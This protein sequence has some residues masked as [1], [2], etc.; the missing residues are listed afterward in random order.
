[1]GGTVPLAPPPVCA[2]F[3][4]ATE[5]KLAPIDFCMPQAS[6]CD[7]RAADRRVCPPQTFAGES[8]GGRRPVGGLAPI[9]TSLETRAGQALI[10]A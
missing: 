4:T 6:L 8:W 2:S 3:L 7:Q 10:K 5:N 1:M 9:N